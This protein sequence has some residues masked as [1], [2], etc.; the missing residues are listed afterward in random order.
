MESGNSS[1]SFSLGRLDRGQ[2]LVM[3]LLRVSRKDPRK[4]CWNEKGTRWADTGDV[5]IVQYYLLWM[6][7]GDNWSQGACGRSFEVSGL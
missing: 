4:D 6:S 7:C 3:L 1:D 2:P 5:G